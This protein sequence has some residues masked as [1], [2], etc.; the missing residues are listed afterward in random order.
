VHFQVISL[1]RK[2]I[3]LANLTPWQPV[4][5]LLEFTVFLVG[6]A[7]ISILFYRFVERPF[8]TFKPRQL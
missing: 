5:I 1:V 8:M 3:L 2:I 6:V 7:I 4:N